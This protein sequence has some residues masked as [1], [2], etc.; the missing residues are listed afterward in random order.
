M[1]FLHDRV[2]DCCYALKEVLAYGFVR[3]LERFDE[4][5]AIIGL[6]DSSVDTL[7]AE[8]HFGGERGKGAWRSRSVSVLGYWRLRQQKV[9]KGR[10]V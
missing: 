3:A 8:R 7:D 5:D 2:N 9:E 1:I 10:G 4:V 6:L